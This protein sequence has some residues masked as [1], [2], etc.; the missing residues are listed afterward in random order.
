MTSL[1]CKR[2][3]KHCALKGVLRELELNRDDDREQMEVDAWQTML[4]EAAEFGDEFFD[5]DGSLTS[6]AANSVAF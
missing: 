5:Y 1:E 2:N 3:V 6:V 4:S